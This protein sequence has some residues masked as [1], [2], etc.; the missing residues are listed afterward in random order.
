MKR[1]FR[2]PCPIYPMNKSNLSCASSA[3]FAELA[4]DKFDLFIGYIGQGN[5]KTRFIVYSRG[6]WEDEAARAQWVTTIQ[7]RF[8][9]LRGRV[10]AMKVP[11]DRATFRNPT[12]GGEIR[13]L[14]ETQLK[15][16]A[17]R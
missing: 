10:E 15:V 3:Q 5:L 13:K 2:F 1:V 16:I 8:P 6:S 12:T 4:H 7:E 14:I 11:L 9:V 17:L